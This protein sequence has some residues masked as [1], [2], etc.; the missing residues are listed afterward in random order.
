VPGWEN[1]SS[2]QVVRSGLAVERGKSKVRCIGPVIISAFAVLWVCKTTA[3]AQQQEPPQHPQEYSAAYLKADT[4]CKALWTDHAFDPLRDKFALGGQRTFAM[5]T[6]RARLHFEDKPLFELAIKTRQKCRALYAN[7]YE[8]LPQHTRV[9]L[10]GFER[11]EDYLIAR[12]LAGKITIGEY[13]VGINQLVV[14]AFSV[15]NDGLR[16]AASDE[17]QI[18]PNATRTKTQSGQRQKQATQAKT[19]RIRSAL[20]IGNTKYTDQPKLKNTANDAQ[21]VV[22]ALRDLG[23]DVTLV[24]DASELDLRRAVRKFAD[25]SGQADLALVYYAG[26]G[27]QINGENY[28]LPVDMQAPRTE[29]DIELSSLKVDDLVNSIRSTTK[30]FFLDAC[31]DNPALFKNLVTGRGTLGAGLAPTQA[32][33]LRR[34]KPGGG[35]F[36][37]YAADV[38]SVALEGEGE[39]SPF[40]QALL[41]NL[42]EPISIDDMFSLV[43]R[44]V[45]L[46]T[47]G[48][49]RPYKYA[50]LESIVCLTGACLAMTPALSSNII[51]DA[52]RSESDELQ[53]ALQAKTPDALEYYLEKYPTSSIRH[54]A[55][56]EIAWLK[57][58]E[59]NEWTLFQISNG[60]FVSI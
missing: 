12:L 58:S 45:A 59:F 25:Q 30:I 57:R 37:A 44:D 1:G 53:T 36:I 52:R 46:A 40:T 2:R 43:T 42:K 48:V 8:L 9:K 47:K 60:R 34:L 3:Y 13:N 6:D 14:N 39:H 5:L 22:D 24:M 18:P 17:K 38:G 26:H 27:S 55:L 7:A 50:S 32:T 4:A 54:R 21:A 49:Q 15:S 20:V 56:A 35:A 51:R 29:A 16:P 33:H 19:P 31:R 41:N 10:K 28:L 11:K 23:F